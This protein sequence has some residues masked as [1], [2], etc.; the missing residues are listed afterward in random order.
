MYGFNLDAT[1]PVHGALNPAP[2]GS[3]GTDASA[4]LMTIGGSIDDA[5]VIDRARL[6]VY[7]STDPDCNTFGDNAKL[8]V[9]TGADEIS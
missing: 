8:V 5:N 9:G 1:P 6:T 7:R 4:W 2:V 3:S